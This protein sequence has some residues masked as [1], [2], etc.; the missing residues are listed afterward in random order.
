[1]TIEHNVISY[2]GGKDSTAMLLL[3]VEQEVE[4][5]QAVFAD[6]GNEHPSTYEYVRYVEQSTGVPIRWIRA[7]FTKQIEGRRQMMRNV[8]AGTHKNQGRYE[9][10]PEIAEQALGLLYTT[11]NPFLDMCM[12]HG[13]FPSTKVAFCSKEL[14][15]DQLTKQVHL[16]LLDAGDD[17]RS[18]QG[19]RA[20]E[21]AKRALLSASEHVLTRSSGAELWN[22]R[23]ILPWTAEDC[24]EMH[25]KHGLKSNPLYELGMRRVGCMPCINAGKD[26]LLEI[27]KRFPEELERLAKWEQTDIEGQQN[28]G[29][30]LFPSFRPWRD[31]SRRRRD[32]IPRHSRQGRVG[33]NLSRGPSI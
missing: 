7:D 4:H 17:V 29:C 9:W 18:W 30:D 20:D 6:T 27:S 21:G 13:R 14:K 5:L 2:S 11:G 24:F 32:T 15:R 23:P 28:E 3:A 8:I 25:R 33:Y 10:T 19:V 26:E 12:V 31:I 1:M 22:Y 16:P